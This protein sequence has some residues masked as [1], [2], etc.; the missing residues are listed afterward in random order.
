LITNA[1]CNLPAQI[2]KGSWMIDG[3]LSIS[4]NPVRGQPDYRGKYDRSEAKAEVGHFFSDRFVAGVKS[5]ALFWDYV[6]ISNNQFSSNSTNQ[7][8]Y[9][10]PYMRYFF[11]PKSKL[12]AFYELNL[13]G[14]WQRTKINQFDWENNFGALLSNKMGADYFLTNNIALE[15]SFNYVY[16]SA[17]KTFAYNLP[18]FVFNPEFT[19]KLFLNTEKQEAPLLA[20]KYLK[21][22]NLTF[23]LTGL[24]RLGDYRYGN[25]IPSIGYFL[26]DKWMII[27]SLSISAGTESRYLSLSPELRYYHPITPSMQFMLRGAAAAGVFYQNWQTPKTKWGGQFIEAGLGLNQFVSENISIQATTNLT[28]TGD[29]DKK[30]LLSPNVKVGFQYFMSRK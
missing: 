16:F 4:Q 9:I 28:A 6:T 2:Q 30:W 17:R 24:F 22:G 13:Q 29:Y 1:L 19:I 5:G 12:K 15:G 10:T 25:L 20:E 3:G 7:T 27:S 14:D 23:G 11:N 26:T 21:K 18:K 8:F